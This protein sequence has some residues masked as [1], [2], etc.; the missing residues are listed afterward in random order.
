MSQFTIKDHWKQP[1][2]SLN[3]KLKDKNQKEKSKLIK[4]IT[5]SKPNVLESEL[6]NTSFKN[7]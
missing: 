5:I 2:K 7:N 6:K 4:N 3:L 1:D